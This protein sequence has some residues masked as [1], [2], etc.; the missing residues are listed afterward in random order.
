M[1][2]ISI[3]SVFWAA[4]IEFF[5]SLTQI[6]T[7]KLPLKSIVYFLRLDYF[8]EQTKT[9]IWLGTSPNTRAE[10]FYRK[11][12]WTEIGTHGNGEIKFEMSYKNWKKHSRQH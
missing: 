10:I 5:L 9:N 6:F 7:L 4:N 11:A 8:Q 1:L 12:G 3:F 2:I